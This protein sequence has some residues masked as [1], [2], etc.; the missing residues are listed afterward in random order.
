MRLH[1][2]NIATLLTAIAAS[3]TALAAE[4]PP[5]PAA[6]LF[7]T[8]CATCHT[9]GK[10][11]KVGPDLLGVTDRRD[12]A[13][14]SRFVRD[15]SAMIDG[16][17]ADAAALL[18]QFNGVRMPAQQLEDADIDGLWAYFAAC[19]TAGG[20]EPVATGPRWGTDATAEEIATGFKLF[21]G[22]KRLASGGPPCF[23]CHHVRE[24]GFMGGGTLGGDVTFAYAT[25]GE[26]GLSRTLAELPT[27]VMAAI[28]GK[29]PLEADEQ[30]ALKALFASMAKDGKAVAQQSGFFL[31]GLEGMGIILAGLVI[32]W[33]R[34]QDTS[35]G[36]G[37]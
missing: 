29:A 16:G 15:P 28:Y 17:D 11:I 3:S 1:F 20:C 37:K 7:S 32:F 24:L 35:R 27:P 4:A 22:E 19:T 8:R 36:K 9:I 2:L 26:A 10:G 21:S 31:M 34:K 33:M 30:Y 5:S 23:T 6:L 13:W 12:K 14:V 18:A 25:F